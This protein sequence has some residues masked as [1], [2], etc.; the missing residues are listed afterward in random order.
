MH[1]VAARR[2]VGQ[3]AVVAQPGA[4]AVRAYVVDAQQLAGA[5]VRPPRRDSVVDELQQALFDVAVDPGG[6]RPRR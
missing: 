5:G 3:G 6:H 1:R 2:E 4:S